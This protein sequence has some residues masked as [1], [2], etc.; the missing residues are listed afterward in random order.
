M[1]ICK[2]YLHRELFNFIYFLIHIY[3]S[4]RRIFHFVTKNISYSVLVVFIVIWNNNK[5]PVKKSREYR[6]NIK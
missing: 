3:E 6:N 2:Y 1:K 4:K 5:K